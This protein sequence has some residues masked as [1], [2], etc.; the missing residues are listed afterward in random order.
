MAHLGC[1]LARE[2]HRDDFLGL[3]NRC[4]QHQQALGQQLGLA[5]AG[6][7]LDDET[8]RRIERG[9]TLLRVGYGAHQTA[10]GA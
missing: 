7:R 9:F 2:G 10:N 3:V 4:Q 1:S 6:R 8:A 5:R